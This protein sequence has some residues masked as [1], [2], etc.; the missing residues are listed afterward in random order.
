MKRSGSLSPESDK[1]MS[2]PVLTFTTLTMPCLQHALPPV[3]TAQHLVIWSNGTIVLVFVYP[4]H[5]GCF[6]DTLLIPSAPLKTAT[7][8]EGL[9]K[10]R[11]TKRVL[12]S[13]C[14]SAIHIKFL[15]TSRDA[16]VL[17][18]CFKPDV[19]LK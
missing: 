14:T 2:L 7:K 8:Q 5:V 16:N 4:R 9:K 13:K 19:V 10:Q 15:L 18:I 11:N 3:S 17:R 12:F 1:A 6:S